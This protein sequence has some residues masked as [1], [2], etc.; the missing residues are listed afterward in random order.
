MSYTRGIIDDVR[1]SPQVEPL[2]YDDALKV[3][4]DLQE[5][6]RK[7]GWKA[8][9]KPVSDTKEMREQ[10][11][12]ADRRVTT[13]WQAGDKYQVMLDAGLFD[14]SRHPNEERYLITINIAKPWIPL[15]PAPQQLSGLGSQ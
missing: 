14:D 7:G 9:R 1:M 13:V 11:R 2:L 10:L 6:W 15:S 8:I 4:L 5:Q 3:I 12:H